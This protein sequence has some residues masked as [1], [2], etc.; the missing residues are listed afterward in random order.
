MISF[1]VVV[2][3]FTDGFKDCVVICELLLL[4]LRHVRFSDC[5]CCCSRSRSRRR[6]CRQKSQDTR[7]YEVIGDIF[8]K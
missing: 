8:G 3:S 4:L 7:G 5:R 2:I 1:T 6:R